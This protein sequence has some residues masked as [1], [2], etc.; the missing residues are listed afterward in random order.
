[1]SELKSATIY[2][3]LANV[4]DFIYYDKDGATR[5]LKNGFHYWEL[6]PDGYYFR[7]TPCFGDRKEKINWIRLNLTEK[8][9]TQKLFVSSGASGTNQASS[10]HLTLITDFLDFG[11]KNHFTP[12]SKDRKKRMIEEYLKMEGLVI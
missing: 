11:I 5:Y 9:N 3:Q 8:I 4:S 12:M 1:M 2:L 6:K 10:H 7:T